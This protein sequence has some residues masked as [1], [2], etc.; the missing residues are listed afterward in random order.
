MVDRDF[1]INAQYSFTISDNVNFNVSSTNGALSLINAALDHEAV[2]N[3]SLPVLMTACD[4][5]TDPAMMCCNQL[6][7]I[8]L[9]VRIQHILANAIYVT[10]NH[11]IGMITHLNLKVTHSMYKYMKMLLKEM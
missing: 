8:T 5:G 11:R 4:M 3:R 10:L 6:I 9:R 7:N 2:S 1:G